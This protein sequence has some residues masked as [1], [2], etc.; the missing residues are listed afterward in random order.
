MWCKMAFFGEDIAK[1]MDDSRQPKPGPRNLLALLPD[2][3]TL[4]DAAYIRTANGHSAE[5]TRNMLNQWTH[6]GYI[7][8]TE[9]GYEKIKN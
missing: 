5:G 3:F 1:A 9:K 4:A 6:R 2:S 7:K 8:S